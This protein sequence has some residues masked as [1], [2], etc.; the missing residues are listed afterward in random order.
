MGRI[1]VGADHGL[2]GDRKSVRL[3]AAHIQIASCSGKRALCQRV[4]IHLLLFPRL[5]AR[6]PSKTWRIAPG[7][8]AP[9]LFHMRSEENRRATAA[10]DAMQLG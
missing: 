4:L 5:A 2:V 8:R 7:R 3:Q 6:P 9:N 1:V 10:T